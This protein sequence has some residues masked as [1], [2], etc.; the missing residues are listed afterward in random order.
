MFHL[1]RQM[2]MRG[3]LD[4]IYTTYPRFKMRNEVGVPQHKIHCDWLIETTSIAAARTGFPVDRMAALDR[5]KIWQHDRWLAHRVE[6][7]D[8]FIALSGT[9]GV[10]GRIAQSQGGKW[11]C[12]RGSTHHRWQ[13]K[14][15]AE[16][17]ACWGLHMPIAWG[18]R[19]ERECEEYAGANRI[20][21]PSHFVRQTFIDEGVP[22]H[23]VSVVPY[24]ANIAR[25]RPEGTP[26]EDDFIV[27]FVG[28]FGLRKGAPYLLEA[29]ARF[30]HPRKHLKVVGAIQPEMRKLLP[31]FDLS[32]VEFVGTVPN[33]E[34]AY[35]YS[36]A[37]V[38]VLPSIEE[39]LA[40]VMGEALACGTPVVATDN[41]G[42][43]D[44]FT[45]GTEG[46]ILPPRNVDALTQSFERIADE[47]DLRA[48]MS[49]AALARVTSLEGWN[50]YG[51]N[52][53]K[54]LDVITDRV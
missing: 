36:T 28:Q 29:F 15:V 7:C 40:M 1:A 39:G 42:A 49:A 38:F 2:E 48:S 20:V 34:L 21:V 31:K 24:G 51:K 50:T 23:K 25:F 46:L 53:A 54:V 13:C 30:R 6:P 22:A 18:S 3:W 33:I 16:E 8:V 11:V 19:T 27:L 52:Y 5:F 4:A 12:D 37:Q 10:A 26:R 14:T 9:G 35:H 17:F 45:H 47:P 32:N 41:T 44:L 43:A